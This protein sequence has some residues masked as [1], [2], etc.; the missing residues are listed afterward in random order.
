MHQRGEG[1]EGLGKLAGEEIV[2]QVE[3]AEGGEEVGREGAGEG[4]VAEAESLQIGH[5]GEG[6]GGELAGEAHSRE[7]EL[8]DGGVVGGAVDVGSGAGVGLERFQRRTRPPMA[9]GEGEE[10]LEKLAG[11]EIVLQVEIAEE[12][13]EVG[14]EGAGEGVVAEA[15]SLQIGHVG[16][17]Y[18]GELAGEAHS[19]EVELDDGGVV[20]GAVDVG[21]GAG[22]GLERFQRRT[23]PPTA[24]GEGEEG[25]GKLAG[26]EIVL[27]VEIAE[28]GEEV[29]REGAGEGVVAEAESLQIGHVGE[30][31]GGELAGEAHSREVELDDGGVV[32][33]AVDVG[34]GAGVG[35]ERF[36]RRT[37]PPT[38][39]GEGEEGLG[40][41]AGE[42][43]VLQVEIA[44]EGEEVGREGAGEGVVAEAESLQIGH[45]GEGYGGELA[46]EAHSREVELDDGGVVG[47]AVDV[48]SGAGVGLERFQR[49]T[50]PPTARG[51]G[52]EGLGKLAG[53]EIV[54]QVEIAEEGEE[55][56]RE[57]AGEGVVAEAESLQIGH[58][59]EGYGGGARRRG[60][61]QG[62]G[63]RRRRSCRGSS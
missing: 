24:R 39:R 37:R 43:I 54:L 12:G 48:G 18:G 20:G 34:S 44:E 2:L 29:G 25:L 52:E 27:Q 49:R 9:R 47:G 38:A 62:S 40:K 60:P 42:E 28:E 32:G 35:L 61:F 51:E 41:L 14:R 19:R 50:R 11:E 1:E 17:G 46:G 22:V 56:G 33:G 55:V 10:G 4:V 15:E 3:I 7:V 36:Q 58:V 26:E 13:K 8:D 45:V 59:G 21:P 16:E 6:Y 31:Y 63:A 57:G 23:R 5:V 53:E 30:G